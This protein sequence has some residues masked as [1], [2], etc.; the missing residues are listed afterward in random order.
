MRSA[1]A[2]AAAIRAGQI[3]A[4][5]TVQA[6]LDDIAS[7]DGRYRACSQTFD[8][9]ALHD[10]RRIDGLV[11]G[12]RDPGPLAGVPFL[13]KGN[14]DVAGYVTVAGS[15]VRA[16]LP[17]AGSDAA[18][19]ARL[20]AAGAI[21]V[22]ATHMD[23]LACGATG[24]NP[25]FGA[26][27]LPADPSRMTG[28]SSSG[29]AA[30]VAAGYVPLALGSDTNGSIRA[31]A[32]LCGVWGIRPGTQRLS[33][34]GCVPYAT[35]LDAVGGFAND[36]DDLAA[37]YRALL[38]ASPLPTQRSAHDPAAPLRAAVLTGDFERHADTAAWQAVRHAAAGLHAADAIPIDGAEAARVRE[39]AVVVSNVE[40]ARAHRALLDAPSA[41]VSE[42]L[43]TRI[44]AG[45]A[46]PDAVYAQAL[47][48]RAAWRTR[49]AAYFERY[50]I[51][52]AATTP[53]AAPRFTDAT[54]DV[55]GIALEPAKSLG[56][57]TQPI[58]FADLPV[59]A[60]PCFR[61]GELPVGVQLIGAPGDEAACFAAARRLASASREAG[62]TNGI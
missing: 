46:T 49:I 26:V 31:P 54:V 20:A 27:R 15:P 57:L 22:G 52:I 30:A 43:R 41:C 48:C 35:T 61:P 1:L 55:N 53:Y 12:G 13:V 4:V 3:D 5:S 44:A 39:A 24:V 14:F 23:E 45:A 59:I 60:A 17:P 32:A 2:L 34:T 36:I 7:R 40:L 33:R 16:A 28:G 10:A 18:M 50:D 6:V 56:M 19:V 37:L 38:G 25:H 11:R 62:H 47:A 21:P 8:V 58:S 9:R 51:L 29:S 42:R